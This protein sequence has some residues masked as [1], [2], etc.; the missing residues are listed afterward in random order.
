[1]ED[2]VNQH[3]LPKLYLK[4]F[5]SD[6]STSHI[7]EYQRYRPYAPG[8]DRRVKYNPVL[9]S[10]RLAGAEYGT[11]AYS[12]PDGTLDF[13][14]YEDALEQLEKPADSVLFKLRNHQ[15]IDEKDRQIF[16]AYMITTI[17]RVPARKEVADDIFPKVLDEEVP[18]VIARIKQELSETNPLN[19][20]ALARRIA[21]LIQ[22]HKL[23]KEYRRDGLPREMELQGV[24]NSAMPR[25]LEAISSMRWQFLI[26]INNKRFVTSDNPVHTFK[27]GIGLSKPYSE[28]VFPVSSH[29]AFLG[30]FRRDLGD[31]LLATASQV[32]EINRRVVANATKYV[33]SSRNDQGLI[34]LFNRPFHQFTLFYPAPELTSDVLV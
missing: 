7:W 22:C 27:G 21:L 2:K 16:A 4:G 23:L 3:F 20:V 34:S 14:T 32:D 11:Y 28:L 12:K 13:N 15:P 33:Y 18:K 6:E 25:V 17:L 26:A 24:V 30:T 29:V 10:L 1:M 5:A 19:T 8:K 9:I 31:Y